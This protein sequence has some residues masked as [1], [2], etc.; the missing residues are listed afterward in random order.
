MRA[1]AFL[2][3]LCLTMVA[4]A[5]ADWPVVVAGSNTPEIFVGKYLPIHDCGEVFLGSSRVYISMSESF[6]LPILDIRIY[7]YDAARETILL[8]SG[9][10]QAPGT[11]P[12]IHGVSKQ[13]WETRMNG[14]NL[15][16]EEHWLRNGLLLSRSVTTLTLKGDFLEFHKR[17]LGPQTR[18]AKG[19]FKAVTKH[20]TY[21]KMRKQ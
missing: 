11:A 15:K 12:R 2:F 20:E 4:P 14:A 19:R 10:R 7:G 8:G 9:V 13:M 21:C 1:Q 17:E 6:G 16:S 3:S 18:D 5:N